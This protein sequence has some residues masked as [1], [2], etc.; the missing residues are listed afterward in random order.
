MYVVRPR[1][2]IVCILAASA[3]FTC[4]EG[5]QPGGGGAGGEDTWGPSASS[6]VSS[7]NG[8]SSTSGSG[9]T[10]TC[11]AKSTT[12]SECIECSRKTADGLCTGK[13]DACLANS[14]CVNYASCVGNCMDGD[15]VCKSNCESFYPTGIPIYDAYVSCV[16]CQ[17][18]Y[19]KCD[20]ASSC[21]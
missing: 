5:Q 20:G 3:A 11:E 8:S 7:S 2:I 4:A 1:E 10:S 17:D 12:C 14:D 16:I 6:S 21:M 19:G 18:C 9:G 15:A 13:Y